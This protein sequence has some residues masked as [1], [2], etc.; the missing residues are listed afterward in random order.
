VGFSA[1]AKHWF[2]HLLVSPDG[3]RFIFLHRWR[4]DG[5]DELRLTRACSP[6]RGRARISTCSTRTATSHF[7]WRDPEH[8]LAWAWHPSHE[9]KFY[10]Y[11]DKTERVEV[12]GS[13]R[14]DGERPLHLPAQATAGF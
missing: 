6:R 5:R 12:V 1:N 13:G 10:L 2:N 14:H 4:G 3:T 9:N 7:I 8:V 11:R